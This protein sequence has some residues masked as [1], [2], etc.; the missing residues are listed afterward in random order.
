[1]IYGQDRD[2]AELDPAATAEGELPHVLRNA[3][4]SCS[5]WKESGPERHGKTLK[6]MERPS[7]HDDNEE[8]KGDDS[9]MMVML[10]MRRRRKEDEDNH[11]KSNF[12]LT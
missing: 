7:Y 5:D 4:W 12:L 11:C 6:E 1:M 10:M 9:V 3:Q 8:G 2:A